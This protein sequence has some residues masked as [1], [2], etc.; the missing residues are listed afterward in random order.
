MAIK[1]KSKKND[2]TV[3]YRI[4]IGLLIKRQL[5]RPSFWGLLLAVPLLGYGAAQ[6]EQEEDGG[7]VA[8]VCVED[9][10]FGEQIGL[11]LGKENPSA[12][13]EGP[14]G[15]RA[16]NSGIVRFVFCDTK[17][18]VER[19]V[20][21]QEAD[22]GFYIP[23]DIEKRMLTGDWRGSIESYETD[24]SSITGIAKER[25]AAVLFR[26]YSEQMYEEYM[27]A[28][29]ESI[30]A[31][32]EFL[33]FAQEAY[34]KH[35]VDGSTFS[36][37][38]K[39]ADQMQSDPNSQLESDAAVENDMSVFPVKGVFSVLI[40]VSGMCGMLEY[41]KDKKEKRF[42]R[43][44]P[45]WM[46]YTVNI[47]IYTGFT[48]LAVLFC[49][50]LVDG[51]WYASD[52]SAAAV[53]NAAMWAKQIAGL[54]GYQLVILFY[55]SIIKIVLRSQEAVATAIPVLALGCLVCC[56]VVVRLAAYVPLFR[57]LEKLF[58][59]TYYLMM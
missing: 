48:S 3:P 28:Q 34:E 50:R 41:E 53:W 24:A 17:E 52:N 43:L 36:F 20:A 12:D 39:K 1:E 55:C 6:L 54:L 21:R 45:N 46:T 11:A 47:V 37:S 33:S 16:E 51:V 27:E 5:K 40:F 29:A 38:Y 23:S 35:L 30:G 42:L 19:Q 9:G 25:I 49:L 57:V 59:A 7:I 14:E 15:D 4:W 2:R 44:I 10:G 58:P 56:P 13:M 26:H 18:E 32:E 31:G 8:A 22:C